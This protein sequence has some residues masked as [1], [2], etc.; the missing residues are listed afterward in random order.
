MKYTRKFRKYFHHNRELDIE[1]Y[2]YNCEDVDNALYEIDNDLL[3]VA[4]LCDL[5]LC[6]EALEEIYKI[7]DK[8]WLYLIESEFYGTNRC[9]QVLQMLCCL[10]SKN[11][12]KWGEKWK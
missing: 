1:H 11:V 6:D 10:T 8:L 2:G 3:R 9:L 7:R 4:T 5:G 12:K